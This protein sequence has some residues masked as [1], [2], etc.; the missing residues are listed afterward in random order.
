[1]YI[2]DGKETS[3]ELKE[4]IKA[5][6]STLTTKPKLLVILVG[7][8]P[9]SKIY[10]ASKEKACKACGI[11][12]Q[13]ITLDGNVSQKEVI[14]VI[15]QANKDKSINA[16]LVQLPLPDHI[17]TQ[18]VIN[19]IDPLKDVDG[20]TSVN[21]GKL[22]LGQ[23]GLVPCTPKG[24]IHLLDKYNVDLT[25]KNALVIGRSLLVG[26]PL[27]ILLLGKNATVTI[28]HS[29][30]KNLKELC[31]GADVIVSSVGRPKLVTADM[32]K[33]GAIVID[34]G[35]NRVHGTIVGDVDY[36]NVCDKCARIT[37][38]PGGVGPMTIACLLENVLE[39]YNLQK[40]KE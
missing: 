22:F 15:E 21:Q 17:N 14:D 5:K 38:V 32:V 6:V 37:P 39:C 27:A 7:E 24:V 40:E 4:V 1:M 36:L 9:A 26:K 19:A 10:V 8:D 29:K 28:A 35:I 2:M 3:R 13:T 23:D 20:L 16:I 25:G 33:E 30:T 18:A 31:L 11:S 34:V 12:A